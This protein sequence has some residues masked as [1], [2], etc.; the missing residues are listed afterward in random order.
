MKLK[1]LIIED[2]SIIALQIKHIIEKLDCICISTVKTALEAFEIA[3]TY[4]IDFVIS[5]IHIDGSLDGIDVCKVLQ[6]KYNV[7]VL[8]LTAFN[9]IKTLQKASDIYFVGY[10][11][12]P[13]RQDELETIINI[14]KYKNISK[15]IFR[16]NKEYSYDSINKILKFK[17]QIIKLTK[18]EILFLDILLKNKN[19]IVSY[20][21]IESYVWDLEYV[22]ENTRRQ[23]LYRFTTKVKT[24]PLKLIK[25]VGYKINI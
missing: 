1:I 7:D 10:I 5:D 20:H 25:G 3:N 4:Q 9:D 18:K 19:N 14:E 12:K 23:L 6:T 24:F 22:D 16:I 11:L 8:F 13:F 2:D 15:S 21:D 17:D